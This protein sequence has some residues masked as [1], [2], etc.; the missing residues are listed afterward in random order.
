[1]VDMKAAQVQPLSISRTNLRDRGPTCQY[2]NGNLGR[3][4]GKKSVK[5]DPQERLA[6]GDKLGAVRRTRLR[7]PTLGSVSVYYLLLSLVPSLVYL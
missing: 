4:Y 3:A 1:M 7:R 2:F 5:R 6:W